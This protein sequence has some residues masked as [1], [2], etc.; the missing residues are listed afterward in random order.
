[1]L[2]FIFKISLQPAFS[3]KNMSPHAFTLGFSLKVEMYNRLAH[4]QLL[5]FDKFSGTH[6]L[7]CIVL[8]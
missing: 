7:I 1:M 6:Q 5:T 2:D 8:A 4:E 3:S